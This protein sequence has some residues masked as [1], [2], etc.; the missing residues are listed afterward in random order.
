MVNSYY[1]EWQLEKYPAGIF[2]LRVI[3]KP[4]TGAVKTGIYK[5]IKL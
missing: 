5:I 2:Y 3:F 1:Q 4:F